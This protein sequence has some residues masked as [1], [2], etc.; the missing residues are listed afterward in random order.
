[1]YGT[2]DSGGTFSPQFA[3]TTFC[4]LL[5][6]AGCTHN[7]IHP[8]GGEGIIKIRSHARAVTDWVFVQELTAS[9]RPQAVTATGGTS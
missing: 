7:F 5:P 8:A 4:Q 6:P 9:T 1:M 3:G 2:C